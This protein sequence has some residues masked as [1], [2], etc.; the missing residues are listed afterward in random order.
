MENNEKRWM[1]KPV[2]ELTFTD[3]GMFQAV[4]HNP[5]ICSEV[6]ERLL[7]VKV[8]TVEYPQIEKVIQPYYTTKSIRLDVYLKDSDKIIDVECQSY[9][10][11]AIGKRTRFYQSLI[12]ADSLIK[13]QDYSELK[14]SY[15]L[16]ICKN[17]PFRDENKNWYGLP[18]YTFR[19]I[20]LE[21]SE[22][23]LND[24]T[25]KVIYNSSAYR[26][27]KDE[28]IRD[29]LCFVNTNNPGK[30]EF[31]SKVSELV[32]KIKLNE[33]FRSQYSAMNLHDRDI[34][35]EAKEEG[36]NEKAI[37]AARNLSANGVSTDIIAK[38][39]NMTPEEVTKII[40]ES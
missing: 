18:C 26:E 25:L 37:E 23:K 29:F 39:L 27:V 2:D 9:P 14:E 30:D 35:K 1:P 12:D 20:C 32:E 17:D 13:G 40:E 10:Q 6:I 8:K 31:S 15:I 36:R 21:K 24:K 3:D 28:K 33:E 5:E 38:S 7:H 16:F 11:D 4:M 22:V 34:R 19:N